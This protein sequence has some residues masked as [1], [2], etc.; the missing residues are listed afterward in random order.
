[1]KSTGLSFIIICGAFIV[2]FLVCA[3]LKSFL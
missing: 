2:T 1:M 3:L